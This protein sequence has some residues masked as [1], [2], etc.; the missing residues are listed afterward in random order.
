[1]SKHCATKIFLGNRY[2]WKIEV[3]TNMNLDMTSIL[4]MKIIVQKRYFKVLCDLKRMILLSIKQ[5]EILF[6]FS[7]LV[8]LPQQ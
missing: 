6:K 1:M 8:S 4:K 2:L 5:M 7:L 3:I